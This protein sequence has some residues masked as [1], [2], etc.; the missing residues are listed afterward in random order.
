MIAHAA[1]VLKDTFA[2][3]FAS[4]QSILDFVYFLEKYE[5]ILT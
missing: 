1:L 3:H 2:P 5:V 4:I